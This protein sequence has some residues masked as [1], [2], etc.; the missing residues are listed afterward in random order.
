M[1][2]EFRACF[3]QVANDMLCPCSSRVDRETAEEDVRKI[4]DNPN[5]SPV[6]VNL[7]WV[8]LEA[9]GTGDPD[10]ITDWGVLEQ[11]DISDDRPIRVFL[12]GGNAEQ[13]NDARLLQED[14]GREVPD[15]GSLE[16]CDLAYV[17]N[18]ELPIPKWVLSIVDDAR[19]LHDVRVKFSNP[20]NNPGTN[21]TRFD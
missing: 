20:R 3:K 7:A 11:H 18:E 9:R 10:P 19:F 5:E 17:I 2:R 15:P 16:E 12:V 13:R 4:I 8:R 14:L 6:F 21:P 1:S